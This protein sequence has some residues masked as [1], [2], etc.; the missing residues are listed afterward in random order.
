MNK[1]SLYIWSTSFKK[2]KLFELRDENACK[3]PNVEIKESI[4]Q[5]LKQWNKLG[6]NMKW[7]KLDINIGNTESLVS[8]K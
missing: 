3:H 6:I 2:K 4:F 7:N 8:F 5:K 1:D